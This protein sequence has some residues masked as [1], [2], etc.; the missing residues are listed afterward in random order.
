MNSALD[1]P[2]QDVMTTRLEMV[3]N[4]VPID[5]AVK[6]LLRQGISGV[7]VT[8]EEGDLV[9]ILSWK[10]A[11]R[12]L[13]HG[14]GVVGDHMSERLI[15]VAVGATVGD[16]ARL[17]AHAGVHRVVVVDNNDNIAGIVSTLDIVRHVVTDAEGRREPLPAIRRGG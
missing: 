11:L 1:T 6:L 7:V 8:T 9:G 5:F 13:N 12:A 16:A 17:M 3:A 15:A 14:R 2:I 10:D 4:T